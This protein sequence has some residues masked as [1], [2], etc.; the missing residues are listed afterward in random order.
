LAGVKD[1]LV[2]IDHSRK[3]RQAFEDQKVE[4]KL[5]EFENAGH[6]FGP[7]DLGRAVADMVEWFQQ[8][9]AAN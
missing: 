2:P 9:L 1:D 6:G 7:D 8:H 3:I 5:V 4:N